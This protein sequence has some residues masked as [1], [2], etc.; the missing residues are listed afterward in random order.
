ML[1][2]SV[3]TAAVGVPLPTSLFLLAAGAIAALG[4]FNIALLIV[5]TITA[6]TS[7]DNVGYFIGRSLGSRVLDWL[8]KPRRRQLISPRTITQSRLYFKRRG[9]W[10]IF[11][12]RFLVSAL[13]GVTNLLAGADLYPYRRF[14]I[15]DITGQVLGAAIPLLLG[16]VVG[17]SWEAVG[18]IL[19][20][21]SGFVL[22]LAIVIFLVVR[23]VKMLQGSK[24]ALAANPLVGAQPRAADSTTTGTSGPLLL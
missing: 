13:G 15:Y 1:W 6:S 23:L 10:A 12:S 22:A 20:A 16:Y 9:G 3:F 17:A 21:F 4:D 24:E 7:G 14:L 5:L 8:E 18:D 2:L 19:G 11:L